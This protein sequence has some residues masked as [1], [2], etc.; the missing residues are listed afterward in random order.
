MMDETDRDMV[1]GAQAAWQIDAG[2]VEIDA[3]KRSCMIHL[4]LEILPYMINK[5]AWVSIIE[6]TEK[7]DTDLYAAVTGPPRTVYT[8]RARIHFDMTRDPY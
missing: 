2:R 1:C 7:I 3:A 8:L 4:A 6:T 5:R